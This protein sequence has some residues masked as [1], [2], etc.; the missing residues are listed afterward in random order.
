MS[1]VCG[2]EMLSEQQALQE[3]LKLKRILD[4]VL[5]AVS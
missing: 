3:E 2:C 4:G 1:C 5:G